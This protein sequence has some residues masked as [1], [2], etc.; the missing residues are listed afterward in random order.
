MELNSNSAYSNNPHLYE[1]HKTL[2]DA[3][4]NLQMFSTLP[5]YTWVN[6]ARGCEHFKPVAGTNSSYFGMQY[7]SSFIEGYDIKAFNTDFLIFV[8]KISNAVIEIFDYGKEESDLELKTVQ[9]RAL[10]E[11]NTSLKTAMGDDTIG[12][13]GLLETHKNDKISIQLKQSIEQLKK[14][15]EDKALESQEWTTLDNQSLALQDFTKSQFLGTSEKLEYYPELNYT[16]KEWER[17]IVKSANYII[18]SP[19]VIKYSTYS[20]SLV[21][22]QAKIRATGEELWHEIIEI[23]GTKLYLGS[24]PLIGGVMGYGFNDLTTLS[25]RGVKAVGSLNE[26]FET[27][28]AGYLISPV[29]SKDWKAAG[30]KQLQIPTPDRKPVPELKLLR[31]AAWINWNIEN[32]RD[33]LIHCKQGKTRSMKAVIAYL[34]VYKG[35][36]ADAAYEYVHNKRPQANFEN[37]RMAELYELEN[38]CRA[39]GLILTDKF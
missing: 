17:E 24:M 6:K 22:E 14:N 13:R 33:V 20:T 28:S 30:I 37:H 5:A 4:I 31:A 8:G 16:D 29:T 3:H 12:L 7:V 38:K 2:S 1:W 21:C 11:I 9:F 35:Y 23:D 27:D 15:I 39:T 26:K 18:E 19:D 25:L 34:I 10:Q 32:K 36:T